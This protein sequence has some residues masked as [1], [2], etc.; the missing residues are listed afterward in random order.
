MV[1]FD[2]SFNRND[3]RELKLESKQ[4]LKIRAM[5]WALVLILGCDFDDGN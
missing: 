2:E 1:M 3:I 4:T 5:L